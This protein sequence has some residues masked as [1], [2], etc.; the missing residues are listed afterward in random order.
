M[1]SSHSQ[2]NADNKRN[3]VN[4]GKGRGRNCRYIC[5][6]GRCLTTLISRRAADLR[7]ETKK[8]VIPG[9]AG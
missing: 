1:Y 6:F 3:V 8:S 4:I 5:V 7:L 9:R 2:F